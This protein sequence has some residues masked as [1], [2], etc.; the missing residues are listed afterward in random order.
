MT[1]ILLISEDYIK[2]NSGLNDNVWGSYL[3]PAIRE[4]QDIKLQTILG[5][6]LYNKIMECVKNGS[7]KEVDFVA[8][9]DLL[10]NYIQVYL[11]YQT[12]SDLVPIIGVKLTNL[13]VVVS[14]D[15][16]LS[17][18]SQTDR[19]R[20]QTYYEQRADFYGRRLQEFLL[21][22]STAF[23]ELD[24]CACKQIKANLSSA[25]ST[26]LWLGGERGRK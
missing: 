9:K 3:T 15:E 6:C 18:L 2:T 23:K 21:N 25:A 19:D 7:I 26:G 16:H 10:D 13:G 12:I 14:N 11:M 5:T 4:A 8:Y 1:N 22:N 17:N 24:E 20:V